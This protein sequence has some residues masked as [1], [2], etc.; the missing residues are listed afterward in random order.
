[1]QEQR[2]LKTSTAL[3]AII[4]G[5]ILFTSALSCW[6][7]TPQRCDLYPYLVAVYTGPIVWDS[8]GES[9][10]EYFRIVVAKA[11]ASFQIFVEQVKLDIEATT[12]SIAV[13]YAIDPDLFPR[14]SRLGEFPTTEVELMDWKAWN[15]LRV[16]VDGKCYS[17]VLSSQKSKLS[18]LNCSTS[19]G[20]R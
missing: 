7:T 19:D 15:Q 13:S 11:E 14:P 6:A 8:T 17:V 2:R 18:I 20:G 10:G 4:G 16:R 12:R 3:I 1:M 9:G 5:T